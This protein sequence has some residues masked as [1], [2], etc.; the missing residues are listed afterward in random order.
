MCQCLC[1]M[2]IEDNTSFIISGEHL[3]SCK[4]YRIY[5]ISFILRS[6]AT[7]QSDA[8][9]CVCKTTLGNGFVSRY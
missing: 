3:P 8:I 4:T 5:W 7:K 2:L 6:N 1:I 9:I